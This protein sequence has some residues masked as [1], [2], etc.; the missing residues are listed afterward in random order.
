MIGRLGGYRDPFEGRAAHRRQLR[1]RMEGVIALSLAI[2]AC[3]LTAAMW[4]KTVAPLVHGL[5]G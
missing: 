3:G 1:I 5:L 2:T 4:L